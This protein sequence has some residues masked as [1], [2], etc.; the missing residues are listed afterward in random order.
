[1]CWKRKKPEIVPVTGERIALLFAINDYRGSDA[2]LRGCLNDIDDVERK[3]R[4]EFADF[5]IRKFKDAEV[6]TFRF[7]SEIESA[8]SSKAKV[9]YIHYS[10]HGTQVGSQEALYLHNGILMDSVICDL[11]N[12]T[13]D[14]K[15]VVAKFDSCFSGG[16]DD[17]KMNYR[18]DRFYAIPGMPVEKHLKH[19]GRSDVQKW[20]IFAGCGENQTSAD[21]YINGRYNGAFTFYDLK[22]YGVHYSYSAEQ[23]KLRT[24]LPSLKEQFDQAP[25]L[26]GPDELITKT[27]FTN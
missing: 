1:M 21:A 9:I 19:I 20:V 12:K 18:K 16:M 27:V 3:L 10:G 4:A 2:D 7:V 13:P 5:E 6:T 11:Q 23:S 25:E 8:L 15:L 22:S 17:R 24:Y 26:T 14:D